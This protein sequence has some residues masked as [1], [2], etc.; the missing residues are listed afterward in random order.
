MT[1]VIDFAK[2]MELWIANHGSAGTPCLLSRSCKLDCLRQL[3]ASRGVHL[4]RAAAVLPRS[5]RVSHIRP[6]GTVQQH[7]QPVQ[8]SPQ[9]ER[10]DRGYWTG[11]LDA[12]VAIEDFRDDRNH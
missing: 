10:L 5:S 6:G 1:S 2:V 4:A 7:T 8:Q 9:E 12:W 11:L 3:E